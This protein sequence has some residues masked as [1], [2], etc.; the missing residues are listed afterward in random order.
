M[1][2]GAGAVP[3]TDGVWR[4]TGLHPAGHRRG[5]GGGCE[6]SAGLTTT[7]GELGADVAIG[8]A[9]L[10]RADGLRGPHAHVH[11]HPLE[12]ARSMPG[13]IIG[14]Q[15]RRRSQA[16]GWPK[17]LSGIRRERRRRTSPQVLLAVMAS[18]YAVYHGPAGLKAI[19]SACTCW[20]RALPGPQE[21]GTLMATSSST[22]SVQLA[23]SKTADELIADAQSK[24]EPEA[25]RR[26]HPGDFHG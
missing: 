17:T 23:T 14:L 20:Q 6:R 18:M 7:P 26:H 21:A 9:Q 5:A 25:Y 12:Y 8:S 22:P 3:A 15:G 13:R 2:W 4:T 11:I 1:L 16:L 24:G 10:R 19:A